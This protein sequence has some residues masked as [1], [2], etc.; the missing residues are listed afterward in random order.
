LEFP[1]KS[2]NLGKQTLNIMRKLVQKI[3]ESTEWEVLTELSK[4]KILLGAIA[5]NV[6]AYFFMYAILEVI[7]FIHYD[8]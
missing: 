2:L 7:L 3:S 4:P 1:N 6:G 8:L 5:F